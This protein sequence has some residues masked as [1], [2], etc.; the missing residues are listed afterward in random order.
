MFASNKT[1]YQAY[2]GA[3]LMFALRTKAG[4][5]P[6]FENELETIASDIGSQTIV[7]R[8][9]NIRFAPTLVLDIGWISIPTINPKIY[10]R[11]LIFNL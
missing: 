3:N 6:M 10:D 4:I 5:K 7:V 11:L 8:R 1:R 9:A 2:V